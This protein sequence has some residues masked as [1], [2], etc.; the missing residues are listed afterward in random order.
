MVLRTNNLSV[1]S[2][3]EGLRL[4]KAI[5]ARADAPVGAPSDSVDAEIQ[6]AADGLRHLLLT[7]ERLRHRYGALAGV[8]GT[9]LMALGNLQAHGPMSAAELARRLGITRSSVTALVDRLEDVGL[10]AR[11]PDTEDRR[12]LRLVITKQGENAVR[13]ARELTVDA[14]QHVQPNHLPTM[15]RAL[16][17]IAMALD[18]HTESTVA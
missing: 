3:T 6:A 13:K 12:R 2:G 16:E 8:G 18:R 15:A 5:A 4:K 17:E 1:A 11:H 10:V 14:L 7:V 9:D